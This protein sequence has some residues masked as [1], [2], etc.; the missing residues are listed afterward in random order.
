MK[1]NEFCHLHVHTQYS[2]LDG[3]GSA[4]GY[5]RKAKELE[6]TALASTDHGNIDGIIDFQRQCKKQGIIPILGCEAYIVPDLN[7]KEKGEKRAHVTLLIKTQKGFENLC[8]MLSIANLEGFYKRPRIDYKILNQYCEGLIVLTGCSASFLLYPGGKK[9]FERLYFKIAGD[10][11][12]EVMPH[13]FEGQYKINQLCLDFD[14][15]EASLIGTN[16]CHYIEKEDREVQEVLLAIQTKAKWNDK[17]RFRFELDDLYLKSADEMLK[18]FEKIKFPYKN[19]QEALSNTMQIAD[20]CK[21]FSISKKQVFLPSV[22]GYGNDADSFLRGIMDGRIIEL[23]KKEGWKNQKIKE[24]KDRIE[25]EWGLIQSKNFSGY[26]MIVWELVKWC[27]ENDIMIGPG[28][29]SAAGSLILYLLGV[30]HIDPIKFGLLFSRF[31][32]EERID[33]PDIDIDFEDKKRDQVREHL[34]QLYGENNISSISTFLTMKG[35]AAVRDVC[36]VFNINQ[37]EVDEFAKTIEGF[38]EGEEGIEDALKE[39]VGKEF[40]KKYKKQVEIAIKLQGQKRGVSQHAA[41]VI[42]SAEDLRKGTRGNLCIRSGNI[43]IN[44]GMED[45]EYMGLMKLDVLGLNT[46]S[47]L[48]ETNKLIGGKIIYE[49]IPLDDLRVYKEISDGNNIGIFQ[50][51]TYSTS[52]LAKEIRCKNIRELSDIIALVRPGP[53]DSGMT[54]SYINR[55]RNKWKEETISIFDEIVKDTYGIIVYQEQIMKVIYEVAGLPYSIADKIR[56]VISKK[57]E[58]KDFEPFKRAFIHGCLKKGIFSR[59]QAIDFWEMLQSHAR[60]SFNLSHSVSYAVLAYWTAYMK[61]YYPTE[62]ICANLTYGSESKKEELIQEAYRLGLRLALPEIGKSDAKKWVAR[63][64]ILYI[65]FIEI[66]GIGEK[67]AEQAVQGRRL[68][69]KK[70]AK[71]ETDKNKEVIYQGFFIPRKEKKEIFK[72]EV[73]KKTKIDRLLD[74]IKSFE[75]AGNSKELS[76]YFS[77]VIKLDKGE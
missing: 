62:F 42:I 29:G 59:R 3:F 30:T 9:L 5:V 50:L 38:S 46:L 71:K 23:A 26:F 4:E 47:I 48:N 25:E 57:R 31:I 75:I 67:L 66:K 18:G 61:K 63:D 70:V 21:D 53:S 32:N 37:K 52:K 68:E 51:N 33:L 49:E 6:F 45:V 77:F 8:S 20:K 13:D 16:D 55:K 34:E 41:G 35:R 12:L 69:K 19:A 74:E 60:Y 14:Y 73:V 7:I 10:L 27:K 36:R 44:W 54:N 43:V 17:D 58:V 11:Y 24:Y 28:R 76:K 22:S 56:K 39:E 15:P 1:N 72:E 65:P 64:K 40:Y 2:Y